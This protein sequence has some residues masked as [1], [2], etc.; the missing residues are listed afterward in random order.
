MDEAVIFKNKNGQK[1]F[2][3]VHIPDKLRFSDRRIGVNLLNP[4]LKYRVAPHR[5]NV[6]LARELCRK[7]YYVLRFDPAG[8]GDSEGDLP[9][10]I[11]VGDIWGEIQRGLF[12]PDT[13]SANDFF[14]ERYGLDGL[15]LMGNCGGAITS[16][17]ATKKDPRIAALCMIDTPVILWSSKMTFSDLAVEEGEK[18]DRLY[19]EYVKRIFDAKSWYR[20]FTLKTDYR[21]LRKILT[22]RV[23]AMIPKTS[24]SAFLPGNLDRLC[25]EK[26][27]NRLFFES[28]QAFIDK[29]R[30]VL[31]VQAGND[32][33][34]E[35]FQK[36][37]QDGFL[38]ERLRNGLSPEL[39]EMFMIEKANHIYTLTEWQEMLINRVLSWIEKLT[40]DE[41]AKGLVCRKM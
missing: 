2:G 23:R 19:S 38:K 36:Y 20:F 7:G 13:L 9:E 28:I 40:P 37:F 26:N 34:V 10:G 16:L 12:V 39:I 29:G 33:G 18:T 25:K 6:K 24:D 31:F 4:G 27:L 8:I 30:P 21:A 17:L 3:I 11:L 32:P 35:I 41:F 22:M 1:L 14:A 5:L 15:I